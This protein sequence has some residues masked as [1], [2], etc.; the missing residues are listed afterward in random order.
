MSDAP[1][2]HQLVATTVKLPLPTL[3]FHPRAH[4]RIALLVR[5]KSQDWHH[6]L[7]SLGGQRWPGVA[8][9]NRGRRRV[10]L[11]LFRDVTQEGPAS[12]F[13]AASL[14]KNAVGVFA[15]GKLRS[16]IF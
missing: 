6:A 2:K 12:P 1:D 11:L 15:H 10:V 16:P 7:L 14:T 8:G 4:K 3:R 9:L 5:A 13:Y